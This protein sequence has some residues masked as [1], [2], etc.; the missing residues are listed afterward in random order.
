ML[1]HVFNRRRGIFLII[2]LGVIIGLIALNLLPIKLYPEMRKPW[3][4]ISIPA[5]GY[6]AADYRDGYG[7]TIE[8]AI[9]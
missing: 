6:T 5:T 9:N 4:Q 3:V 7:D 2:M 8:T 1:Q